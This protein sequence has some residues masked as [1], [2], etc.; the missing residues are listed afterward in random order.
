MLSLAL[1]RSLVIASIVDAMFD[2]P[3]LPRMLSEG[4]CKA[5][6]T[7]SLNVLIDL[8][9]DLA[10]LEAAPAVGSCHGDHSSSPSSIKKPTC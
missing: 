7:S 4:N 10:I 9:G 3:G 6:R 2:S 8:V 1:M 5:I